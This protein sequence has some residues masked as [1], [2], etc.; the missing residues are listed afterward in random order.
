MFISGPVSEDA[1]QAWQLAQMIQHPPPK[2]HRRQRLSPSNPE[3]SV[4]VSVSAF[5]PR[6]VPILSAAGRTRGGELA[7]TIK[8]SGDFPSCHSRH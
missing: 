7:M 3:R 4:L 2:N 6:P 1:A 8:L 5:G